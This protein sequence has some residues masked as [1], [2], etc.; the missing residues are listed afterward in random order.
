MDLDRVGI[1]GLGGCNGPAY[2][3]LAYP[4]FYKVGVACSVFDVRLTP[5]IESYRGV[6][7]DNSYKETVVGNLAEN[8]Q[9][10]LL[11][12]HGMMD[13][14][15]QVAGM[16]QLVDSFVRANKKIDM[17]MLPNGGHMFR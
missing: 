4:E 2:G 9:G 13:N 7:D 16:L 8:L 3:L 6:G 10:N 5:G 12:I 17:L 14:Y 1:T 15:F 11:L